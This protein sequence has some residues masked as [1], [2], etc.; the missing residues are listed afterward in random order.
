MGIIDAKIKVAHITAH[1]GG[2][3]GAVLKD[4]FLKS[5]NCEN[6][7]LCLDACND[8]LSDFIGVNFSAHS[9]AFDVSDL[10]YKKLGECDVVVLHYWNH[11][12]MAM[13]LSKMQFPPC[14]LICWC[15]NSGLNEPH[16]IP[17]YLSRLFRKIIFTSRCSLR[18][19]NITNL[20][21]VKY[22]NFIDIIHSTRSL[23]SFIEIGKNR[24]LTSSGKNFLYVGTVS[25]A[26]MHPA[27]AKIFS[28]LSKMG[29]KVSVV[30]GPDHIKFANEVRSLGGD[31]EFFGPINDIID[32]YKNADIFIYPLRNDHYG[33][34]EQVILEA[35]ASGLPIISFANPAEAAILR[36]GV[37]SILVSSPTEFTGAALGLSSSPSQRYEMSQHAISNIQ[38]NFNASE[39]I[40]KFYN[41][42]YEVL[43]YKKETPNLPISYRISENI[44][45]LYALHSFYD[46]EIFRAIIRNP[47]CG[48]GV[49]FSQLQADLIDCDKGLKWLDISKSTPF[50]Y[51]R[52]FPNC[53]DLKNLTILIRNYVN[54]RNFIGREH[55]S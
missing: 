15:H 3:V 32:F 5:A 44:L 23:D 43:G 27:S 26:K 19:P 16:I 35:L 54:S 52:Y 21:A 12:L 39:M 48:V 28:D 40:S 36:S 22:P 38:D 31:I 20:I 51:Q 9:L 33:T 42:F 53:L 2:G 6:Y 50:H 13:F 46:E 34:G 1:V 10:L 30:G 37:D 25:K 49:L 8:N 45:S 17:S 41:V 4:L 7:L 55:H 11:P 24:T 18:A 47:D 14:R 29:N